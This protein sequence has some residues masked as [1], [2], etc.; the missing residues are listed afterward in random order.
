MEYQ[1]EFEWSLLVTKR[2]QP[3]FLTLEKSCLPGEGGRPFIVNLAGLPV[4]PFSQGLTE[5]L[6]SFS[7]MKPSVTNAAP[8]NSSVTS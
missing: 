3:Y 7:Y 2:L 4:L 8:V 6:L 5:S 1:R